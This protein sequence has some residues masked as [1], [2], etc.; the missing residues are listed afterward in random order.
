MIVKEYEMNLPG[1]TA[2]STLSRRFGHRER[3]DSYD[4]GQQSVVPQRIKLRDVHCACDAAT[5][6]CICDNGRVIDLLLGDIR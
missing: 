5:D 3:S 1:F 6:V 4:A 2:E